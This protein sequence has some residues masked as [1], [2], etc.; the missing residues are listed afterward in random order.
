MVLP[1]VY[2]LQIGKF[3]DKIMNFLLRSFLCSLNF[4]ALEDFCKVWIY[5]GGLPLAKQTKVQWTLS[6]SFER[7]ARISRIQEQ[8]QSS[9]EM[10]RTFWESTPGVGIA[11]CFPRE[12]RV[13]GKETARKKHGN[14]WNYMELHC[15]TLRTMLCGKG[16]WQGKS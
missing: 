2:K 6:G 8:D 3:Y 1:M 13:P 11:Y 5:P 10:A 14:T 16:V 7:R 12:N 15:D 4:L 9:S